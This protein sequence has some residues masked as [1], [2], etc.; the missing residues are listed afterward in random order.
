VA[1]ARVTLMDPAGG[2]ACATTSDPEGRYTLLDVGSGKHT[3]TVVAEHFRPE[4]TYVDVPH[5]GVARVNLDLTPAVEL[6]G[7]VRAGAQAVPVADAAV[8]LYACQCR[9][10]HGQRPATTGN[11]RQRRAATR[12]ERQHAQPPAA[13]G[14]DGQLPCYAA[15]LRTV[16]PDATLRALLTRLCPA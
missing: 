8:A 1:G 15:S 5:A 4:V 13:T 10:H 12:S 2:I 11:D 9:R 6:K 14:S 7:T 3:M 16:V